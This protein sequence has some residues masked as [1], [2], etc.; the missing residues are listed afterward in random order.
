MAMLYGEQL[1][2]R[3]RPEDLEVVHSMEGAAE[4][5]R[6]GEPVVFLWETYVTSRYVDA[7]VMRRVDEV[8]GDW[9]GFVIVARED[10]AGA[11]REVLQRAM[12]VLERHAEALRDD[13]RSVE[14]VMRNAGFDEALA[15]EW[16]RHVQWKVERPAPVVLRHLVRTLRKLELVPVG[17][18]V[19][20]VSSR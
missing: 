10:F 2:W 7:G 3:P 13:P 9:P 11:H 5:M 8:R 20:L 14:L 4:R 16:L 15:R 12:Q 17:S 18:D 6:S 19:D 1:G